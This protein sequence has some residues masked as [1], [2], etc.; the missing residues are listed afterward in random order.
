MIRSAGN[1][2]DSSFRIFAYCRNWEN[3]EGT[4][5]MIVIPSFSRDKRAA[6]GSKRAAR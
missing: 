1:F 4:P 5:S 2:N 3:M 6:M